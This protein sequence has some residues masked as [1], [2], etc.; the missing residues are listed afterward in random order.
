MSSQDL[1]H[2]LVSNEGYFCLLQGGVL[3]IGVI[4][5]ICLP[6]FYFLEDKPSPPS[7]SG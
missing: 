3:I 5:F 4:C 6:E 1:L 7:Y 2:V